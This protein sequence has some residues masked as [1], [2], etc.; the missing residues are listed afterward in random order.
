MGDHIE[1]HN[2]KGGIT[3]KTVNINGEQAD[4]PKSNRIWIGRYWKF[5]VVTV[6]LIAAIVTILKYFGVNGG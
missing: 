6:S 5:I 4:P 3:A 2:Q 1:S